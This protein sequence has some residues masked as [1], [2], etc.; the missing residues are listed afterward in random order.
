MCTH[1]LKGVIL[2]VNPAAANLLGFPIAEMLGRSFKDIMEPHMHAPFDEYLERVIRTGSDRGL[3]QV[4]TK[5]GRQLTW[6]Y[7][8]TLDTE[9]DEPYVLGHAQDVTER[10][11]YESQLRD[12]SVRDAL[13]GLFNRRYLQQMAA[14][15]GDSD[16]CGCIVIDLDGFKRINDTYGHQ[17]GDEVLVGM[18]QFLAMHVRPGDV[19]IRSGGDEFTVLLPHA[20]EP[21]MM[22]VVRRLDESRSEAPIGFTLGHAMRSSGISLD[23]ALEMADQRLYRVRRDRGHLSRSA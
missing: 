4:M 23:A 10:L 2:A 16:S 6:Q 3:L 1:D 18:G 7:H 9:G 5:D 8:N 20:R 13:T 14:H 15:L 22:S 12:Q 11:R 17:R 21:D 19:V